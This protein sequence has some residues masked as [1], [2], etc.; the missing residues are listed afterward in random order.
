MKHLVCRGSKSQQK[1]AF[2][3]AKFAKI[4][5]KNGESEVIL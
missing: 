4:L 5:K 1:K 2:L 3:E